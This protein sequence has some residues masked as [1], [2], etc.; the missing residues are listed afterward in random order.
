MNLSE[1]IIAAQNQADEIIDKPDLLWSEAEWTEYAN[2]A[3]NET[4]IR[5][6]LLMDRTSSLATITVVS[7]IATY[8]IDEKILLIKRA[9]LSGSTEP[10]VKTSR[11]VLDAT[12]PNWEADTGTVRSWLPDDTNKI[13]LYKSPVGNDTLFL[14]ISRLPLEAML[15][16][17]K[18]IASPEIDEQYHLGLVD[19]MLFRCYSKQDAETLDLG[20]A[21][22]HL[23]RF[24]KRFGERP[25]AS[26]I[27][28]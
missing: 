7:G 16:A 23:A 4:C 12:F 15:L 13:T 14:M 17:D 27:N 10:L 28:T 8:S 2:D 21:K 3:E 22:E 25:P 5:A 11:R 19:W 9:K 26:V 1:L 6:N 24:T 20:K 18:L